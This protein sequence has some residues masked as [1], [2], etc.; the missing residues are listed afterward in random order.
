MASETV[1]APLIVAPTYRFDGDDGSWS[2]FA[3]TVG[4]PPQEFRVL[5]ATVGEEVLVP[6]VEGCLGPLTNVS[7]C[8]D[9]RGANVFQDQSSRGFQRNDSTTWNEL[10]R[11]PYVLGDAQNLYG[12][13]NTGLYGLDTVALGDGARGGYGV[14][15][16]KQTVAGMDQQDF[17]LGTLGLGTSSANFSS[18]TVPSLMVALKNQSMIPSLSYGYTAGRSY[19]RPRLPGSLI[20]GGYDQAHL[21]FTPPPV[22]V[23]IN[24][25][26]S[27]SLQLG[28]QSITVSG[29]LG[30]STQQL[31]SA[32]LTA[33]IDSSVSQMWLPGETCAF[34]ADAFG[35]TYT[36]D[37]NYYVVNQTMHDQLK[38][39][40]PSL[41]FAV[42]TL[43]GNTVNIE[44]PWAAF[45][46][47]LTTPLSD[48][49][50]PYF[51]LRQAA[52][53][54]QYT[55]GRVFL[56]EAYIV[57]N[58]DNATLTVGQATS[59]N[60][61]VLPLLA[62]AG[63]APTT[64]GPSTSPAPPTQHTGLATGTIAGIVIVI[65]AIL[66]AGLGYW[67]FR[68]RRRQPAAKADHDFGIVEAADPEPQSGIS[69]EYY[70]PEKDDAD[71][72]PYAPWVQVSEVNQRPAS[73][74]RSTSELDNL[75]QIHE[76]EGPVHV[77]DRE[78]M[79]TPVF[80]LEGQH[81]ESELDVSD[82]HGHAVSNTKQATTRKAPP[83]S[84][85]GSGSSE[86][87]RISGGE[88]LFATPMSEEPP[89]LPQVDTNTVSSARSSDNP[90]SSLRSSE[91]M[92]LRS[93]GGPLLTPRASGDWPAHLNKWPEESTLDTEDQRP[94]V[95]EV[96]IAVPVTPVKGRD[97]RLSNVRTN[98]TFGVRST[99]F[100]VLGPTAGTES[101]SSMET[102]R[103]EPLNESDSASQHSWKKGDEGVP[104]P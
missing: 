36:G 89:P 72:A 38:A 70:P 63:T 6:V 16:Q 28:V 32:P 88:E 95:E 23:P 10:P 26:V 61:S 86:P 7:N 49:P 25:A 65:V 75:Q 55:L 87:T 39:S 74:P 79:S 56:Q 94:T 8:G 85:L 67:V 64:P 59:Q 44:F 99:G 73:Y 31:L 102:A 52:N 84:R 45:D 37:S 3:I 40:S 68:R 98:E 53:E 76:M 17:W 34:F 50:Y 29:A 14:P 20:I 66:A 47:N 77:L 13:V 24:R 60:G 33:Y 103:E 42:G 69:H 81:A 51:P 18:D 43:G 4:S 90:L 11:D 30:G 54:S 104:P 71:K 92:S 41:T 19:A 93:S 82:R 22:N 58:W 100:H 46:H 91:L 2:T 80:E 12:D 48:P 97:V 62:P 83:S 9:L 5:P 27:Q 35:L 78:L 1:P 101:R 15:L 21:S 96:A 57:A